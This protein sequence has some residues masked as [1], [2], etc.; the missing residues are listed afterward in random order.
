M[1]VMGGS[2]RAFVKRGKESGG[3]GSLTYDVDSDDW[4]H[5]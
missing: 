1:V 3:G 5:K 4:I 2:M